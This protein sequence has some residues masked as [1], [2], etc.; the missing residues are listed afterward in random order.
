MRTFG[1]TAH[2]KKLG[3]GLH[4]LTDRS[5]PG[6]FV[7]Y[8]EGAK[9]YRIYD[10]VGERIYVTRDVAFEE[11]R[12]WRWDTTRQAD[13]LSAPPSFTVEYAIEHKVEERAQ[14]PVAADNASAG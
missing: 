2:V 9:A 14:S 6:I 10:P 11:H 8:E 4:K 5:T 3:P 1:C 7:G 13:K 12:A